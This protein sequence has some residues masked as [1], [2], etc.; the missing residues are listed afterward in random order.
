MTNLKYLNPTQVL[1]IQTERKRAG[2]VMMSTMLGIEK[3]KAAKVSAAISL[4]EACIKKIIPSAKSIWIVTFWSQ[5]THSSIRPA[6]TLSM[7]EDLS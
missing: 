3:R 2:R 5:D 1:W 7:D 4:S 6:V